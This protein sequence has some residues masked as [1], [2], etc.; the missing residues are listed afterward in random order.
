M[1]K[2]MN[3]VKQTL[4]PP[5]LGLGSQCLDV[6]LR[7]LT[8]GQ[9]STFHPTCVLPAPFLSQRSTATVSTTTF[10]PFGREGH[11][12]PCSSY[13]RIEDRGERYRLLPLIKINI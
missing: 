10:F 8:T 12:E 2:K 11:L 5:G 4:L 3:R 6:L 9:V 13:R 1:C 7:Q